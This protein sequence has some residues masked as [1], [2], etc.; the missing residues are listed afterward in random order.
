MEKYCR[1]WQATDDNMVCAHCIWIP[2]STN[3][4]LAYVMHITF[5]LQQLLH[6]RASV[7]HHTY[8]VCL[9]LNSMTVVL[10]V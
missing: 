7:L 10:A 2:K 8:I 4:H 6:E 5:P 1:A 3:A 9:V